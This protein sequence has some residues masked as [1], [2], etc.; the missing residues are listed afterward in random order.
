MLA[1]MAI[2]L[3]T[4]IAENQSRSIGRVEI[5]RSMALTSRF[6]GELHRAS[7]GCADQSFEGT[8]FQTAATENCLAAARDMQR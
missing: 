2:G 1:K 3:S 7:E 8:S 4:A 6:R 5:D